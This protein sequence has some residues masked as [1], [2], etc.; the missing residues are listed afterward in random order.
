MSTRSQRV[1]PPR[2]PPA[3]CLLAFVVVGAFSSPAA[4]QSHD[5]IRD[6][7][8]HP[9]RTPAASPLEP[10]TRLAIARVWRDT[11]SRSVALPDLGERLPFWIHR[12]SAGSWELAGAVAAG[13][14]SRF[15]LESANNHFIEIR[16][17]VGFQLRARYRG[18]AFRAELYHVSSHLGD[19][20]I[21][22]TGREPFS[23]SREGVE[24]LAQA[25]PLT[26]LSVYGGP[27][28]LLGSTKGFE[29]PSLRGGFEWESS[30]SDGMFL[31]V[32][33]DLFAWSELDWDPAISLET[34]L[35]A[36]RHVRLALSYGWGPSRA[37]QFFFE[38]E[39]LLSL[40]F[41]FR[42]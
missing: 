2:I 7:T 30:E 37:E 28:W 21:Q 34:G 22:I 23:T 27:G 32:A 5:G 11:A 8:G 39:R 3:A 12:D 17:R 14:F 38:S 20:Y 13:A 42:R 29:I 24:L 40:S 36:G 18:V 1:Q 41:A 26:G 35:R 33:G 10:M 15:D 6:A 25:E 19:E 16:F 9:F 4:A 31:F